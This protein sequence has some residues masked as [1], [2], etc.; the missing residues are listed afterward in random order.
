METVYISFNRPRVAAVRMTR[1]P[2]FIADFAATIRHCPLETSGAG[3]RS[4]VVYKFRITARPNWLRIIFD[5]LLRLMFQ[6]ETRKRL[7]SLKQYI[8][9]RRRD[10]PV[11]LDRAIVLFDG[12]CNLCNASVQFVIARDPD[13]Y[14]RFAALGSE[15]A[16]CAL[17]EL[18]VTGSLP[19]SIALLE[20]GGLY[21]RSTAGLRI[22]R[23][24]TFPWPLLWALMIVPRPLRD[25]VYDLIARRRYRWFGKR[26]ACMVPTPELAARFLR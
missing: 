14:F 5:P 10:V 19:D 8:E 13:G 17:N 23:R 7:A 6:H 22:A 20:S 9:T 12:V 3:T 2:W 1:G 11:Q 15:A 24:L 4:R 26:A 18:A 21:T 16:R 25:R